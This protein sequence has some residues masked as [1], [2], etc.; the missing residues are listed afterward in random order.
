MRLA[1]N[2]VL[3][4]LVCFSSLLSNGFAVAETISITTVAGHPPVYRW[5]RVI[6]DTF[7]PAVD[8][9]LRDSPYSIEWNEL[10]AGTLAPVGGEL[11][12]IEEGLAE[13]GGVLSVFEPAKLSPQNVT[14][15]TPFVTSD[16]N[17]VSR[18]LNELQ[19]ENE[20]MSNAWVANDLEYLGGGFSVDDYFLMT[21]FPVHVLQDLQG[22]KIAAPGPALSWLSGT[23]AIGVAGDL[24]TYY[25]ELD[26]GVYDGVITFA[27]AALP[28]KLHEI[29]PHILQLGLGAQYAGGLAAN[30]SWFASQPPVLQS[31]LKQAAETTRR[32]YLEDLGQAA[33]TAMKQMIANGAIVT[34]AD[35][36]LRS[37]WAERMDNVAKLWAQELDERDLSGTD[38]LNLYMDSIR[39]AGIDPLRNWDKD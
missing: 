8:D 37:L 5:V 38:V 34:V 35:Q 23:E 33:E 9:A 28:A 6:S 1:I 20:L 10:Y 14:Y 13:L 29:A 21:N 27:T 17:L 30:R 16:A 39:Q 11:E 4:G 15:Y 36:E 26:T 25:N 12:A 31:A 32:V 18:L 7:I 3:Y 19:F 2:P 24:T 22:R